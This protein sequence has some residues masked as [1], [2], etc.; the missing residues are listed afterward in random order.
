MEKSNDC[1]SHQQVQI[2]LKTGGLKTALMCLPP[3]VKVSKKI[4]VGV[5]DWKS[6]E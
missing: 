4:T 5:S 1:A 2:W 6:K 3:K